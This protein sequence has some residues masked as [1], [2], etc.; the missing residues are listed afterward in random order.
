MWLQ[1]RL[2]E[3]DIYTNDEKKALV[4]SRIDDLAVDL[5]IRKTVK[6]IV[7]GVEQNVTYKVLWSRLTMEQKQR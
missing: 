6:E 7:D 1:P 3:Y 2:K 4:T 5:G